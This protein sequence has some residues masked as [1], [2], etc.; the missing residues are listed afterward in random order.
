MAAR[1]LVVVLV[2]LL[3]ASAVAAAL[4]PNRRSA[5]L[6]ESTTT[7]TTAAADDPDP[8]GEAL[9]DRIEAST[10][11]PE[12]VAAFVG[13]QYEIDVGSKRGRTIAIEPLGLSEFA[14]PES[15][16]HFDLLLREPGTIPITDAGSGA[17]VGR[18]VVSEPAGER[19]A[20]K[21]NPGKP[22][23]RSR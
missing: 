18:I 23:G 4:A 8:T 10:S 16:A 21:G 14:G 1:R 7:T 3:I 11:R 20:G 22:G 5:L 17:V 2:L 19:A 13:D 6:P 9:T 12:T 15:P